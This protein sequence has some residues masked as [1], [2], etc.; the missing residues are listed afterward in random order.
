MKYQAQQI[1]KV[2]A[3]VNC[4][5]ATAL[6]LLRETNSVEEAIEYGRRMFGR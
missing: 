2:Q 6:Q 5:Y 4:D 3:A 1:R